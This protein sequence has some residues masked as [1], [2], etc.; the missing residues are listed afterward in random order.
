MNSSR[1][2]VDPTVREL[3][4]ESVLVALQR[5][6]TKRIQLFEDSLDILFRNGM[7]ILLSSVDEDR[8]VLVSQVL[9]SWP[10][11]SRWEVELEN[12][13]IMLSHLV[14]DPID[15]AERSKPIIVEQSRVLVASRFEA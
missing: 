11:M 2:A 15:Q 14:S 7:E 5:L 4:F 8:K 1:Q 3:G 10:E 6:K 13:T 9:H 12:N